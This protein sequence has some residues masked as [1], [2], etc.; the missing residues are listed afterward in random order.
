M[1]RTIGRLSAVKV[2]SLKQPGYYAD[3]GNLY[4]RITR[5]GGRGWIFRFS[6]PTRGRTRDMGQG[7][8]PDL[9]LAE[10]RELATECR[11]MVKSGVDPIEARNNRRALSRV[12]EAKSITFDQCAAAYIAAHEGAWR[13]SKHRQQ[14]ANSLKARVSPVF[15]GLPVQ[16]VDR[17]L[18]IKALNPIWTTLPET[19]GRVRGRIERILDYAEAHGYRPEGTNPARLLPIKT[20][21]GARAR[22]V[23]HHAALPYT[24][25]GTFMAAL[26]EQSGVSA[27]ALQ[28]LILTAARTGETLG[29]TWD[30]IDLEARLWTIPANRIKAGREHRVPL[31]DAATSVL[32]DM[33]TV[34]QDARVFPGAHQGRP[35]S[36]MALLMLLRRMGFGDVTAHGFRSAFRDWAAE[37]TIF[38]GE[39]AEMALAH[40]I[41]NAV[42]AAYRRGDLFEK[43][44]KLM[45]SWAEYCAT[46]GTV[47][48]IP[49][50]RRAP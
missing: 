10:A 23:K 38:P 46:V 40:A 33:Q 25:I 6:S 12:A 21:L 31:S 37:R 13:N 26:Q 22:H 11:R 17:N 28:F 35:L 3:G 20:A 18:V 50:Q 44:R 2:Q 9:S 14:W 7:S 8:Y 49:L 16:A 30:E 47:A 43:R 15:G 32:A 48:V 27:R 5:S 29:A 41:P 19:A 45:E 1:T 4:F 42:E 34:R 24:K 36:E 39:V